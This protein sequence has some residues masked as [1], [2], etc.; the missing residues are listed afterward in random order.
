VVLGST[1]RL[2]EMNIRAISGGGGG[3]DGRCL[4]LTT[5][6]PSCADC[7]KI[8]EAQ[9]PSSLRAVQACKGTALHFRG[10]EIFA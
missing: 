3:K 2:T 4:G 10:K 1:Q 8:W 7:L 6:S 9:P 5:L